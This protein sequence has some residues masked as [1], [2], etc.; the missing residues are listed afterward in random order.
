MSSRFHSV[1]ASVCLLNAVGTVPDGCL[2]FLRSQHGSRRWD[3]KKKSNIWKCFLQW[4]QSTEGS[5]APSYPPRES[6]IHIYTGI[7]RLTYQKTRGTCL[8]VQRP[9]KDA[10]CS[11][12]RTTMMQPVKN[13]PWL[14]QPYFGCFWVSWTLKDVSQKRG[15]NVNVLSV[16]QDKHSLPDPHRRPVSHDWNPALSPPLSPFSTRLLLSHLLGRLPAQ[17]NTV[18]CQTLARLPTSV[19]F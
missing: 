12:A 7:N 3:K 14:T 11:R 6:H 8:L 15:H 16:S 1:V 5:Q 9:T 18:F 13:P 10:L 17:C 2:R 4:G 19:S